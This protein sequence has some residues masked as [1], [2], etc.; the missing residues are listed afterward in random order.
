MRQQ[1]IGAPSKRGLLEAA[2]RAGVEKPLI[3]TPV[4]DIPGVGVTA[5]AIRVLKN[6]LGLP[7]GTAPVGV[8]G[9]WRKAEEYGWYPKKLGRAA[10]LEHMV[11]KRL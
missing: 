7:T 3:L 6:E 8:I 1:L 10:G 4:L 11:W 5:G 9:H 2:S